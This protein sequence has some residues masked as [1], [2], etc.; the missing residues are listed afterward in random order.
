MFGT[1]TAYYLAE[2]RAGS[3]PLLEGQTIAAGATGWT[4]GIVRVHY[5]NPNE[6]R[7]ASVGATVF[8]HWH[9]RIG[10][11]CGFHQTGFLRIVGPADRGKLLR[12]V[13]ML[14]VVGAN[15]SFLESEEVGRL[16]PSLS[17]EGIGGA[18]YE[19]EGGYASGTDTARGFAAATE[20]GVTVR[21][22][23]AVRELR[24]EN[25]RCLGVDTS[26]GFVAGG[27]VV[28][29]AGAWSLALLRQAGVDLPLRTKLVQAGLLVHP[30]HMPAAARAYMTVIDDSTFLA[31]ASS[32]T[33]GQMVVFRSLTGPGESSNR[34]RGP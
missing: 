9:D 18:A 29:A 16:Q 13:E 22:G 14:R 5:P 25:G 30:V 6:A 27:Q 23:L 1:A 12:N 32:T 31:V 26:D 11:D 24:V 15:T 21:Q 2:R 10:G 8:R 17:T 28:V 3:V 20:R 34:G 33:T 4:S 19:P 7:L